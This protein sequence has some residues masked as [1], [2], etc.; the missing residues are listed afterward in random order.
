MVVREVTLTAK[1]VTAETLRGTILE[2]IHM[3]NG[4]ALALDLNRPAR[5]S[6]GREIVIVERRSLLLKAMDGTELLI[7]R[8]WP[9]K[10]PREQPFELPKLQVKTLPQSALIC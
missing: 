8:S 1:A 3:D 10:K 9:N 7:V 5:V 2:P 6:E 4:L